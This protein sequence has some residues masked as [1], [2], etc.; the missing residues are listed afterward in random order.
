MLI[1][2][3][4]ITS[5]SVMSKMLNILA[6][7][8][9]DLSSSLINPVLFQKEIKDTFPMRFR[10]ATFQDGQQVNIPMDRHPR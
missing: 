6:K 5:L 4:S 2:G 10:M 9:R 1:F 7:T 8:L 3:L